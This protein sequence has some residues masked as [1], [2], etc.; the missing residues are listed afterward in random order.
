MKADSE[1]NRE[2]WMTNKKL[3]LIEVTE[4]VHSILIFFGSS[5]QKLKTIEEMSEL[6][7]ELSIGLNFIKEPTNVESTREEIADCFIMLF[8]MRILYGTDNIDEWIYK[9][10]K[11]THE[12][13]GIQ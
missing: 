11:R 13:I 7:K 12:R 9:K 5:S 10:I 4:Y 2:Y 8:Q 3:N 6:T 1:N